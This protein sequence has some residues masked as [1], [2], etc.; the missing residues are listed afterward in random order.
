GISDEVRAVLDKDSTRTF[1]MV[2]TI[3]SRKGYDQVL[4]AFDQ[5]WGE[6]SVER[7]VIVGRQGWLVD[8]LVQRILQHPENGHRLFWL[9][10]VSDEALV[11]LYERTDA[12]IMASEAEGFGL[13]L[14]EAAKHGIPLIARDLPVFREVAGE[15]ALYFD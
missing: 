6:G 10:D 4:D 11:K 2:G 9:S 14:I 12:L 3:E 7:L 5:L 13:P 1:L 15:G 8:D